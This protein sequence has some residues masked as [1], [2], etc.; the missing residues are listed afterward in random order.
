MNNRTLSVSDIVSLIKNQLEGEFVDIIVEGEVSNLSGSAA[1][2]YY[3][4][5]S[6]K[7]SGLSCALFKM[8][9]LRNP[10]IK[11]MKNGD[12]IIVRGPIS[13]YAKRGTF[14]LIAKRI[15]PFGKG[16]LKQQFEALKRKLT[17]KGLFDLEH[18][19]EIPSLP[20]KVAIITCLLY[21]SPSPR[22]RQKSR[23]PSSA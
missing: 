13:V 7:N 11:K 4:T 16:D 19:K 3:F 8:D 18:K 17:A 1:G 20:K 21:T 5:L 22:D 23:M 2:H 10:I 15:T 9:A 12:K 14:Q 6:D